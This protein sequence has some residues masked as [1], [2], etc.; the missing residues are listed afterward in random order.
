MNSPL[1]PDNCPPFRLGRLVA[2]AIA[3]EGSPTALA[4]EINGLCSAAGLKSRVHRRTLAKLAKS[5]AEVRFTLDMFIALNLYLT[6]YDQSLQDIPIFGR[7][8]ILD[9]LASSKKVVFLLG[10]KPR[11]KE[12]RDDIG[13]WDNLALAKLLPAISRSSPHAE[14]LIENV[15]CRW[16]VTAESLADDQFQVALN[17]DQASV[18]SFGSPLASPGSE[19]MLARMF[20]VEAF[21][22]QN[23]GLPLLLPFYFVWRPLVAKQFRSAFALTWRE[24]LKVDKKLALQVKRNRLSCF[25]VGKRRYLV[26]AK[27]KAW[28]IPGV[29]VA[30]RRA[31]GNVWVV[32]AG[33]AGPAT[34]AAAQ[35]LKRIKAELPWK[36][37]ADSD[38]LWVPVKARVK[39]DPSNRIGGDV[40]R[41]CGVAFAGKPML[42]SPR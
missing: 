37:G 1:L 5:P 19:L 7:T 33:L 23:F 10:S 6:K 12:Q 27:E 20:G 22:T 30:Q 16:P 40:R 34:V 13:R 9:V 39:V 32:L 4:E 41:V 21:T 14:Y 28:T 38:V 42:F 25:F 35:L 18:I 2:E 8:G 26:A 15:I 29:I 11:A 17:D 36:E 3:R 24:L 31:A